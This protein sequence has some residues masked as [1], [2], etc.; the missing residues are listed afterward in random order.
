MNAIARPVDRVAEAI[1]YF[2][3]EHYQRPGL[4]RRRIR[5]RTSPGQARAD[6][7][8]DPHRYGVVVRHDG[9]VITGVEGSALRTPW[10]LC[11]EAPA[12]L[13]RLAGMPLSPDPQ[14]VFRH[15]DG[16]AQ[17]THLFDLAGLA[18]AHAA[19]GIE[20]REYDIDVPCI[21]PHALRTAR[22]RV[23]GHELMRWTLDRTRVV[24]PAAFAGQD[25]RSMMGWAKQRFVDRDT[26]EAVMVLR[27]ALF[28]SGNRMYDMDALPRADSTGHVSGVCYVFRDG[29]AERAR[30]ELGSTLDFGEHPDRLLADLP[31]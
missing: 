20:R 8:D 28:V 1:N 10:D 31:D 19:R 25:L 2:P 11:R 5:I 3:L 6:L 26:L 14:A 23:D 27:R 30:R 17:C 4:Y 12:L 7:E 15:T 24:A 9:A 29:V 16:R 13:D 18:A 22:L 21:E